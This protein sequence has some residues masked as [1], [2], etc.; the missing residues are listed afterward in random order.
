[1]NFATLHRNIKI[2]KINSKKYENATLLP[3]KHWI[4]TFSQFKFSL[5]VSLNWS[6]NNS[7][8]CNKN[9]SCMSHIASSSYVLSSHIQNIVCTSRFALQKEMK[10]L[11]ILRHVRET[12]TRDKKMRA[13][14]AGCLN[15]HF[16]LY[17]L[18]SINSVSSCT[19]TELVGERN[20]FH[21]HSRVLF[22]LWKLNFYYFFFEKSVNQKF[23]FK[24]FCKFFFISD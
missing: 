4:K 21:V 8:T 9:V 20:S 10:T 23:Y 16:I 22:S 12:H 19:Q 5:N 3:L 1:M 13:T 24:F 17:F 18:S 11:V 15:T 7:A 6:I 14:F 2:S